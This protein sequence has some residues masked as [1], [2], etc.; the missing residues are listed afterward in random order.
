[1]FDLEFCAPESTEPVLLEQSTMLEVNN[2]GVILYM[3]LP[4]HGSYLLKAYTGQKED[5]KVQHSCNFIVESD[6]KCINGLFPKPFNHHIGLI[7]KT[8][9]VKPITHTSSY[10]KLS[11]Q[12]ELFIQMSKLRKV[13]LLLVLILCEGGEEIDVT[14][15]LWTEELEDMVRCFLC[16]QRAG[17]YKFAIVSKED[18]PSFK[19]VCSSLCS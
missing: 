16:F 4:S 10:I 12:R 5:T 7:N 6:M 14:E 17:M 15:Y 1:M 11:K 19:E 9:V 8:K 13:D 3:R 2:D 18:A